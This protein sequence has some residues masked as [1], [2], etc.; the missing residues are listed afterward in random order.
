MAQ[1]TKLNEKDFKL[2]TPHLALFCARRGSGK[3][4]LM[5]YLVSLLTK[6]KKVKWVSVICPISDCQDDWNHL[7]AENITTEYSQKWI[8]DTIEKQKL[9]RKKYPDY[10]GLIIMDYCMDFVDLND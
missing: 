3:S 6:N 7:G 1:K 9:M 8:L 5:R 4:Y 10:E 2:E